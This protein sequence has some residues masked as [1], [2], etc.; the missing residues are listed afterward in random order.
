MKA[1]V[2][3]ISTGECI[4]G[5]GVKDLS[6]RLIASSFETA[7]IIMATLRPDYKDFN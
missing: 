6:G 3:L 1:R 4:D 7:V 5:I 2:V